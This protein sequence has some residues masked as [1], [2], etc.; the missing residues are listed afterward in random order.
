MSKAKRRGLELLVFVSDLHSGSNVALMPREIEVAQGQLVRPNALQSWFLDC[1]E[2]A[3]KWACKL[4]GKDPFG[5][6][7]N[8]DLIEG[9]HHH[10]DEIFSKR[11]GDHIKCAETLLAPLCE[12][13]ARRWIVRG[14]DCHVRDHEAVLG[15]HLN[16]EDNP[17]TRR[18]VFDRLTLEICGVRVVA[19]HHVGTTSRPWLESNALGAEL[20]SEQLNAVR[21]GEP[22]PRIVAAAHRHVAGHVVTGDGICLVTSAWQGLTTHGHKVVSASR[23]K[24]CIYVLDWRGIATGELPRVHRRIYEQPH[25]KVVTA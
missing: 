10:T 3:T 12:R 11:I 19:K 14:T 8:G 17:E 15:K 9:D 13:A 24:P 7:L 16:A 5:L 18:P 20:A 25:P 23:S 22:M 21:N 6:V 4:A 2:H 1:W